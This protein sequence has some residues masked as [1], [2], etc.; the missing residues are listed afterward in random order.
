MLTQAELAEKVG[1]NIRSVQRAIASLES[2]NLVSIVNRKMM[3]SHEQ[4]E[5]LMEEAKNE[6]KKNDR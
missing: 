5:K 2:D 1:A 3:L 6:R 4:Y